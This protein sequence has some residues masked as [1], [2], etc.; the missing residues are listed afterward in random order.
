MKSIAKKTANKKLTEKPKKEFKMNYKKYDPIVEGYGNSD[1]WRQNFQKRFSIGEAKIILKSDS[2]YAV[3]GL[4]MG[5][6]K[7]KIKKAYISLIKEWHP[8]LNQYRLEESEEMSKKIIA[9]YTIL[10]EK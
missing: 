9:A 5:D 3:L 6:S 7:E 1:E 8:D 4:K 2:P 10:T